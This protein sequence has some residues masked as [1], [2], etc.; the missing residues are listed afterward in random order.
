ML[1]LMTTLTLSLTLMSCG[2]DNRTVLQDVG[3]NLDPA[4]RTLEVMVGFKNAEQLDRQLRLLSRAAGLAE[5]VSV[6]LY[7]AVDL[8]G[9]YVEFLSTPGL[10]YGDIIRE[11]SVFKLS[12][13]YLGD[14]F[15]YKIGDSLPKKY[16]GKAFEQSQKDETL[17]AISGHAGSWVSSNDRPSQNP[18]GGDAKQLIFLCKKMAVKQLYTEEWLGMGCDLNVV[19]GKLQL[20]YQKTAD[21][22]EGKTFTFESPA[23]L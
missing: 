13:V 1:R 6:E 12:T 14:Q 4:Q 10:K 22:P 19:N 21:N 15:D 11:G 2:T 20:S 16:E 18:E 7:G 3:T 23:V 17:I 8:E 9:E 5:T